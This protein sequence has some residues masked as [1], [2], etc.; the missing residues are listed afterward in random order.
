MAKGAR[1]AITAAKPGV[2][3][4]PQQRKIALQHSQMCA[5]QDWQLQTPVSC[6][7]VIDAGAG[8]S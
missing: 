5:V 6:L 7:L 4:K 1:S 3:F 8:C 2:H